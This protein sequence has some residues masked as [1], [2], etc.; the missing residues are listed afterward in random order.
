MHLRKRAAS[1]VLI[2]AMIVSLL[3]AMT[4]TAGA[5]S[6]TTG[7][8]IDVVFDANA[9]DGHVGSLDG[10]RH[11]IKSVSAIGFGAEVEQMAAYR[12][13]CIFLGWYTDPWDGEK[14]TRET[15]ETVTRVYAHWEC[16]FDVVNR[17]FNFKE[18]F[19]N[20]C[21]PGG[22]ATFNFGTTRLFAD[23]NWKNSWCTDSALVELMNRALGYD[24]LLKTDYFFDLRDILNGNC[25]YNGWVRGLA[26]RGLSIGRSE[27]SNAGSSGG[28]KVNY[29]GH[30]PVKSFTITNDYGS[31]NVNPIT[32]T[33]TVDHSP[34]ANRWKG[35]NAD[36]VKRLLA[37]HPEGVWACIQH[38]DGHGSH[39]LM[40]I[41]Y[42]ED[43]FFY[44][45][46]G[47]SYRKNGSTG[48]IRFE[49]LY[50]HDFGGSSLADCEKNMLDN[51]LM[52][53]AYVER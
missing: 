6:V 35:S 8:T 3:S 52:S 31:H 26:I 2:A 9:P 50:D 21:R 27:Y 20:E 28:Q 16:A 23:S 48:I 30:T 14:I 15:S 51:Y 37:K 46:N 39:C 12:P 53:V 47:N 40:I 36:Y 34:R 43:G 42:D 32:Y 1:C 44:L 7:S 24:G 41:G 25:N 33:V 4:V 22:Y 45:D 11:K 29:D 5:T 13:K 19:L 38:R 17:Q 10:R 18:V 49:R